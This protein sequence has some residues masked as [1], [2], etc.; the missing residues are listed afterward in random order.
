MLRWS[1]GISV[2]VLTV[3]L[4]L[5][6]VLFALVLAEPSEVAGLTI[7]EPESPFDEGDYR[8]EMRDFFERTSD[9]LDREARKQGTNPAE[10]L[11][12]KDEIDQAVETRTIH[13]DEAQELLQKLREG[14]DHFDLEWPNVMPKR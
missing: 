3:N 11:P 5:A 13:S 12:T 14:F 8:E 2:T 7:E 10:V 6:Y 4:G 1:I 9:L